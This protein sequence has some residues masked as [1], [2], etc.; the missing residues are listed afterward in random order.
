MCHQGLALGLREVQRFLFINVSTI[1]Q[2]AA[3]ASQRGGHRLLRANDRGTV[4]NAMRG[5]FILFKRYLDR[6]L[7]GVHLAD[8]TQLV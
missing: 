1:I 2:L 8:R 3:Y 5:G 7:Y 4:S 6:V